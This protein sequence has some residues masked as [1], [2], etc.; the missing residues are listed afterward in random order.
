VVDEDDMNDQKP[1]LIDVLQITFH[2]VG[3]WGGDTGNGLGLIEEMD[4]R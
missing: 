1:D 3:V 4:L 2:D